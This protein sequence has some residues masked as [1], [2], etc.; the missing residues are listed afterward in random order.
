MGRM[1]HVSQR[2]G[3]FIFGADHPCG[4][5]LYMHMGSQDSGGEKFEL[6][7]AKRCKKIMQYVILTANKRCIFADYVYLTRRQRGNTASR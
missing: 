1:L 7:E 2:A 5:L 3:D 4:F 6:Q